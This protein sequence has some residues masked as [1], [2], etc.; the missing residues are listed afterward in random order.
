MFTDPLW[1]FLD[2]DSDGPF[3]DAELVSALRRLNGQAAVGPERV[4]SSVIKSVFNDTK[5]RGPLLALMNL[6]FTSGTT[7]MAWGE[8][9]VF[10]LYKL[11]GSRDDPN[12][13]R[14][15]NLIN[16]FCRVYERLLDGRFSQWLDRELPQGKMQFGFRKHTGTTEAF[17][18]LSTV[19]KYFSR[20]KNL[21]CFT[22]FVDLKKA[23]PSVFRSSVIQALQEK[24]APPNSIRALASLFS[25]NSCRLRVNSYLSRPF[26]INRGVKEGGINSPSSF[27]VVYAKALGEVGM[28]ELP[29]DMEQLDPEKV[30]YFVFADDLAI[31]S[32]N[33]SKVNDSLSL[34]DSV[35]PK[36]GMSLNA[37]KT[38]WMP[39]LPVN[40]RY[41]I[42]L[43]E[44]MEMRVRSEW[45]ECVD[46]FPYL[47]F[48]L[49]S[50]LGMNDHVAKKR[51]LMFSAARST[52]RLLRSLQITNLHSIR[53]FFLAFVASQQ[54]GLAMIN[55]NAED[56]SKAMKMFLQTIFCLP[57]SFPHA[58]VRGLLRIQPFEVTLLEAR[59]S[60]LQRGSNPT[61]QI[62]KV[63]NFDRRV[64]Q[65][66]KVGFSHDLVRFLELF[67]DTSDLE[68]LNVEDISYLQDLRDQLSY[69]AND[70]HLAVFS[71]STGLNFWTSLAEDA[72]LPREFGIILGDYDLEIVRIVLIFLGDVI[73]FSLAA[74]TSRCPFC[75]TELHA[76]HFFTCPNFPQRHLIPS[77]G[78]LLQAFR[79]RSWQSFLDIL[80]SGL[81]I[82][83]DY[84]VFFHE[85]ATSNI[86]SYRG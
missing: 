72:F 71:R 85:R 45:I 73:R 66:S 48:Q 21:A 19:A 65:D 20:V 64:L 80:F 58:A 27:V 8:S 62:Q 10:V 69:Q 47:G 4:P 81:S 16:D 53:T 2:I 39:F 6:C 50:F 68:D 44:R 35:L 1:P 42:S 9:E 67:F 84:T 77:W 54:Y 11:K 30:Y 52:G 83:C 15:I 82:W 22:C 63:L 33:F 7:P 31:L 46:K 36:Y 3:S 49:N 17:F 41:Q 18:H 14:G 60:F 23:F 43:P 40:S 24:G 5:T 38:A 75:P 56:Y 79:T 61:S 55:F 12:N 13:Y 34:L 70:N 32:C 25:H 59:I 74:T 76:P 37:L 78:S 57:D 29:E 86:K 28:E 26:A 51:E